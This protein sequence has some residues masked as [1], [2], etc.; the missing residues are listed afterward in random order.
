MLNA[1]REFI[2]HVED[3]QIKCAILSCGRSYYADKDTQEYHLTIGFDMEE[4]TRF[5]RSINFDYDAGFGGQELYGN[6][7][8]T[9]GTWSERGEY[10]GSEWWEYKS[11]PEIPNELT[12]AVITQDPEETILL[13]KVD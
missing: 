13:P 3:R 7:W 9:D 8:Y 11:S 2:E 1:A 5:I 6:I 12:H 4:Y 10:D